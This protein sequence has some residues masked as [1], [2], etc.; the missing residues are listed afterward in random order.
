MVKC[1]ATPQ[2]QKQPKV[3]K[4]MSTSITA[5]ILHATGAQRPYAQSKPLVLR[6]VELDD[7]GPGEVLVRME[8]VGL[9]HSDLSVIE[10]NRPRPLPMVLGHE[11]AGIVQKL[12]AGV[13]DLQVGQRVVS[14]FLARCENC[15]A[16]AT[17]GK[18]P[19]TTA[20]ASNSAGELPNGG[21]RLQAAGQPVH[22]HLGVSAFATHAVLDRRSVV[23][24]GDDV[25][26][27]VAALL[28]CAVLTGGGA[29]LNAGKP[30]PGQSVMIVG[31]GGVGMAGLLVAAAHMQSWPGARQLIAVDQRPEKLALARELGAS[32]TYTPAQLA[33][34]DRSADLVIEAAGHPSAF[35]SAVRATAPGGCTVTVS[36]PAPG[37]LAQI[38]PLALTSGARTIIGSYLGSAIPARDI[39]YYEDLWRRGLLPVQRLLSGSSELSEINEAFDR[40]ADGSTIRQ[41]ITFDQGN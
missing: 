25:P 23:P 12:G 4:A 22:H 1:A 32:E 36:L 15:A 8:A 13:S 37:A 19:C 21:R 2:K 20:S 16:C 26:A 28:G 18:L 29:L 24:V 11:S 33:A 9:C 27:Q 34:A 40:L 3:N 7:P 5:A 31:L 6:T 10:G 39:P 41:L 35:E 17:G 30:T 38:E 14:V